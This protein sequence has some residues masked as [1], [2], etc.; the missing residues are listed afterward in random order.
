MAPRNF[1]TALFLLPSLLLGRADAAPFVRGDSNRDGYVDISDPLNMLNCMF[2]LGGACGSIGCRA[3]EDANGDGAVDL[4]DAIAILYFLFLGGPAPAAPFPLCGEP[5]AGDPLGCESEGVCPQ[6]PHGALIA[7]SDCKGHGGDAGTSQEC[8]E[9]SFSGGVLTLR[10]L[11]AAFNCCAIV[12]AEVKIEGKGISIVE[13]ETYDFAPCACL[14]VFDL[15][16]EIVDLL[17]GEYRVTIAG[18]D[19]GGLAFTVDLSGAP[20]GSHCEARDSYP[21]G[22]F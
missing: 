18:A 3:A 5:P 8:A 12:A 20:A 2:V 7:S 17:S 15:D 21:W 11:S 19:G 4:S 9:Y 22:G 13:S 16:Y 10:H 6:P 1:L 14:C